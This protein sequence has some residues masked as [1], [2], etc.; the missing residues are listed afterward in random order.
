MLSAE[1]IPATNPTSSMEWRKTDSGRC[2]RGFRCD[3]S[4]A[5][6]YVEIEA[7]NILEVY[8]RIFS[9]TGQTDWRSVFDRRRL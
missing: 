4:T 6:N 8:G 2:Q 5:G 1:G 9:S 7:E 3:T